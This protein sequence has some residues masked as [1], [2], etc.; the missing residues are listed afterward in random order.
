MALVWASVG[1]ALW[2][3]VRQRE[4]GQRELLW[5]DFGR[6]EY[7]HREFGRPKWRVVT[8]ASV[9][10]VVLKSRSMGTGIGKLGRLNSSIVKPC[11]ESLPDLS[12]GGVTSDSGS[13]D[14]ISS[15]CMS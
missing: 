5:P 1:A 13:S 11:G 7:D 2:A 3:L 15:G 9:N 4:V 12:S 10:M 14:G 6:H 8:S